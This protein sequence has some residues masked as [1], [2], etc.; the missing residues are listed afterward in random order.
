M[1]YFGFKR[2]I[3]IIIVKMAISLWK[4]RFEIDKL[5]QEQHTDRRKL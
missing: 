3:V 2:Q 4:K 1:F 5:G